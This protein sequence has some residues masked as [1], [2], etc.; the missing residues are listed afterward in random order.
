MA[1]TDIL[2]PK[3]SQKLIYFDEEENNFRLPKI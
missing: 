1:E 2:K 3:N